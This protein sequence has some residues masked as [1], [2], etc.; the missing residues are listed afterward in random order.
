MMLISSVLLASHYEDKD[1]CFNS[2]RHCNK[3]IPSK[4]SFIKQTAMLV[5]LKCQQSNIELDWSFYLFGNLK[6]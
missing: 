2:E 5:Q 6:K 3:N 4:L 1:H